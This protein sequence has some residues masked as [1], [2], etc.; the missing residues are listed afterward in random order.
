MTAPL[1]LRQ[2]TSHPLPKLHCYQAESHREQ[3][4]SSPSIHK[5]EMEDTESVWAKLSVEIQCPTMVRR[6]H[7]AGCVATDRI[8][9]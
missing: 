5:Q 6:E 3:D 2:E 9:V 1:I 7:V 8:W 4:L